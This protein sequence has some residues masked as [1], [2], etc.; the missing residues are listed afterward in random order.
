[1]TGEAWDHSVRN[2]IKI[3]ASGTAV[4]AADTYWKPDHVLNAVPI[5][6]P[7]P[8]PGFHA[9][10]GLPPLDVLFNNNPAL[11]AWATDTDTGGMTNCVTIMCDRDSALL[12]ARKRWLEVRQYADPIADL[13]KACISARQGSVTLYNDAIGVITE[14]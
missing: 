9:K 10:L 5:A 3:T 12:T 13:S 14:T 11:H 1:M 4:S 2:T 6:L 7:P 8:A